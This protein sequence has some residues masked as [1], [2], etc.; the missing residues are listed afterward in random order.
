MRCWHS[1][2]EG[3]TAHGRRACCSR[4]VHGAPGPLPVPVEQQT[5]GKQGT[6]GAPLCDKQHLR[7]ST[8]AASA[9]TSDCELLCCAP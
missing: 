3:D 6:R 7:Y 9:S 4:V 8:T 5:V 2:L 1:Q